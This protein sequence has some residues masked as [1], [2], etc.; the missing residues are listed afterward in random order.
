MP[1]SLRQALIPY[2]LGSKS[3]MSGPHFDDELCR[4]IEPDH[5]GQSLVSARLG[6]REL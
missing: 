4:P 5:T 1:T 3:G 6:R 2:Q